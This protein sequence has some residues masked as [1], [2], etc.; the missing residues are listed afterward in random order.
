MENI[1]T[2]FVVLKPLIKFVILNNEDSLFFS[3]LDDSGNPMWV[4]YIKD[5]ETFNSEPLVEQS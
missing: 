4:D 1:Q 3:R 2:T 5:S